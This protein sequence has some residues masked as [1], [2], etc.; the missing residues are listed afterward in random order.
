MEIRVG[1]ASFLAFANLCFVCFLNFYP[2][3]V[4]LNCLKAVKCSY[5]LERKIDIL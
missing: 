5:V 2:L 4:M 1:K 3:D